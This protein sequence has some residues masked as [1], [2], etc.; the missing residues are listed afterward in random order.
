MVKK[1]VKQFV[2]QAVLEQ[3]PVS[4]EKKLPKGAYSFFC[5]Q[6]YESWGKDK[7]QASGKFKSFLA[8][9]ELKQKWVEHKAKLLGGGMVKKSKK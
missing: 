8:D 4:V 6:E 7:Y 2:E 1:Q 9:P 5:K 3:T